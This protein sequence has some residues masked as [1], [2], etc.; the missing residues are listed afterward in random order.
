MG[1]IVK[2]AQKI[3]L[4]NWAPNWILGPAFQPGLAHY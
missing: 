1:L 2:G 3:G 4:H